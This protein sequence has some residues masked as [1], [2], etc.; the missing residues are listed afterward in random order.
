MNTKLTV[1]YGENRSWDIGEDDLIAYTFWVKDDIRDRISDHVPEGMVDSIME[2]I[3]W[4][5]FKK[6]VEYAME[7]AAADIISDMI[8]PYTKE[9]EDKLQSLRDDLD[10]II[11]SDYDDVPLENIT[12]KEVANDLFEK[13]RD[14][15]TDDDLLRRAIEDLLH[16]T[17]L[18]IDYYARELIRNK[19]E[20]TH[21][22][23]EEEMTD[24]LDDSNLIPVY[25]TIR[26]A[27]HKYWKEVRQ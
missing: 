19:D 12:S 15:D 13:Y 7:T 16:E 6:G 17:D 3:D 2:K 23:T 11:L 20:Y 9:I 27:V 10:P 4:Y 5:S 26:R 22:E 25:F 8:Y 18:D 21:F 14:D 24:Y 1:Y